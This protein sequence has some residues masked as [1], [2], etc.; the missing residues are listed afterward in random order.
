MVG[1][2]GSRFVLSAVAM[3]V[4]FAASA[5]NGGSVTVA[6]FGTAAPAVAWPSLI[7][8]A[9]LLG[10]VAFFILRR[11]RAVGATAVIMLALG[12]AIGVGYAAVLTVVVSGDEC[13]EVTVKTYDSTADVDLVSE[14]P[15]PIRIIELELHCNGHNDG[16]GEVPVPDCEVGLVLNNGESCNLPSCDI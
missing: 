7:L 15:N 4:P 3:L 5:Q 2:A 14:C 8:L 16:L 9:L 10:A 12:A 11:S 6:P 13:H 1:R